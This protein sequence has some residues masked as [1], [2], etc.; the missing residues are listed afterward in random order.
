MTRSGVQ[1]PPDLL[2]QSASHLRPRQSPPHYLHD[3]DCTIVTWGISDFS[4]RHLTIDREHRISVAT[5]EFELVKV[6]LLSQLGDVEF[7]TSC[8]ESGVGA[9]KLALG[10]YRVASFE[11]E[12]V[13]T[14][15][16]E[17]AHNVEEHDIR[18]SLRATR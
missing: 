16:V 12:K 2:F 4:R 9:V 3:L 10:I 8:F 14:R 6:G 13:P 7:L 11:R 17:R 1:F 18:E 15:V 5:W